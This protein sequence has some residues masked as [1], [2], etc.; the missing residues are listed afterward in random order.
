MNFRLL[1]LA[2][3]GVVALAWFVAPASATPAASTLAQVHGAVST[4]GV[5][6]VYHRG[7]RHRYRGHYRYRPHYRKRRYYRRYR[8]YHRPYYRK[9]HYYPRR[10]HYYRRYY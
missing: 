8:R 9:R 1:S 2:L 3:A 6:R 4:D 7:Y 10:R 5:T